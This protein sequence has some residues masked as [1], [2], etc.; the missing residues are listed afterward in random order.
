MI[1]PHSN[2]YVERGFSHVNLIKTDLRN[3]LNIT[4]VSSIMKIESF[5]QNKGDDYLFE[6]TEDHFISYNYWIKDVLNTLFFIVRNFIDDFKL[7]H[8]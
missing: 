4:I 3:L 5:Y 1:I 6:P 2:I 7:Y 8:K